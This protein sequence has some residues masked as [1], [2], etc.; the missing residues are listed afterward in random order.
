M[1]VAGFRYSTSA[2]DTTYKCLTC[3]ASSC[4]I[5][6]SGVTADTNLHLFEVEWTGSAYQF[7]IDGNTVCTNTTTLPAADQPQ[8]IVVYLRTLTAVDKT[9]DIGG[10]YYER[11]F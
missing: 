3:N 9:I 10:M 11:N 1:H 4:T 7:R 8:L 5:N 6:D 2:S